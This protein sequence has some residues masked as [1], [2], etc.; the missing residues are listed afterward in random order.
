MPGYLRGNRGSEMVSLACT[1]ILCIA[2]GFP[3]TDDHAGG[4][5]VSNQRHPEITVPPT[6]LTTMSGEDIGTTSLQE[7]VV[8]S[9]ESSPNGF[10][11]TIARTWFRINQFVKTWSS[12]L[13]AVA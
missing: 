6:S 9:R 7:I 3:P 12:C 2:R 8:N 4:M 11:L 5:C 1:R 13:I 10:N